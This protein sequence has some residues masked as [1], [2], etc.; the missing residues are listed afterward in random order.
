M[1][2]SIFSDALNYLPFEHLYELKLP[3]LV[4]GTQKE[5]RPFAEKG[6]AFIRRRWSEVTESKWLRGRLGEKSKWIFLR[7]HEWERQDDD[8]EKGLKITFGGRSLFALEDYLEPANP[9]EE[10]VAN[11]RDIYARCTKKFA[12]H[13]E[14]KRI[15]L[16]DPHGDLRNKWK[17]WWTE[18]F[19]NVPPPRDV[20]EIW[21]GIFDYSDDYSEGW[22]FEALYQPP[23]WP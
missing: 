15:L 19:A 23:E 11:L 20:E 5:L 4:E 7:Q 9:P 18:V 16:L 14:A 6:A 1:V 3:L 2:S 21:T 12:R 17:D 22:L 10:L 13:Q 8:P